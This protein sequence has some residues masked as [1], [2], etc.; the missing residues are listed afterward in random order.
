[1]LVDLNTAEKSEPFKAWADSKTFLARNWFRFP[2][3]HLLYPDLEH[4][5]A[6]NVEVEGKEPDHHTG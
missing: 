5:A 3:P 1:M 4:D 6:S 2:S